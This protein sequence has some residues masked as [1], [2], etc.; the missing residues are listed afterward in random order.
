MADELACIFHIGFLP[1][2]SNYLDQTGI[3]DV[4]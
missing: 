2:H 1:L 3:V 4:T